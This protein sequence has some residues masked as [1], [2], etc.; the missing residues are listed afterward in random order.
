MICYHFKICKKF[1]QKYTTIP[2]MYG[3][4]SPMVIQAAE[5]SSLSDLRKAPSIPVMEVH[6]PSCGLHV[7]SQEN[8]AWASRMY[9]PYKGQLKMAVYVNCGLLTV[10]GKGTYYFK[11]K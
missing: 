5:R 7:Q 1:N 11:L 6:D 3:N 2:D 8:L 9:Q 10:H 4:L